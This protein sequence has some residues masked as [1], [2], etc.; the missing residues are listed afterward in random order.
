MTRSSSA[1]RAPKH[2][3]CFANIMIRIAVCVEEGMNYITRNI[4]AERKKIHLTDPSMLFG[5]NT[6]QER[7]PGELAKLF[8]TEWLMHTLKPLFEYVIQQC[9]NKDISY[10]INPSHP[11]AG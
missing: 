10:T 5:G 3:E 9:A 7:A 4:E 11:K 1:H 2:N 8:G 6:V